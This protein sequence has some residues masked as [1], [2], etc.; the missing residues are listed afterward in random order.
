MP[1]LFRNSSAMAAL[2]LALAASFNT[3]TVLAQGSAGGSIGNDDKAVSGSRSTTTREAPVRRK[4]AEEPP[5]RRSSSRRSGS[6]GGNF[7]GNWVVNA[8]PG[9]AASGTGQVMISG[10][11][12]VGQGI[13]GSISPSGAI[14]TVGSMNGL[15][16]VSSGR[17][18]GSSASGVYRQSDGC[19]GTWRG[20]RG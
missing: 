10:G 15:T 11:R 3:G 6:S 4:P 19:S 5:P 9:C 17:A 12:I 8:S 18:S 14:R 7:D 2:L 20:M 13:S 1:N 16:V